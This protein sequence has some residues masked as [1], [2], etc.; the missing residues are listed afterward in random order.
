[1]PKQHLTANHAHV[2]QNP[3]EQAFLYRDGHNTCSHGNQ[4]GIIETAP[5]FNR[6]PSWK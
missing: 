6:V 4:A 5:Q 1:M 2:F 3:N